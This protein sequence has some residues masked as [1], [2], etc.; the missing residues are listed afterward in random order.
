MDGPWKFKELT[1]ED[2]TLDTWN[3][4]VQFEIPKSR[5]INGL[6]NKIVEKC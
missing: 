6:I 2:R 3:R 4:V 1:M 5:K